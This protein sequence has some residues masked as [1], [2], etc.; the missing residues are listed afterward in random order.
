[1]IAR[2]ARPRPS[3]RS[4]RKGIARDWALPAAVLII[5]LEIGGLAYVLT[6]SSSPRPDILLNGGFGTGTLQA[7][8]SVPPYLPIIETSLVPRGST[9]AARFQ[10]PTNEPSVSGPCL[11]G[12]KD[13]S[14]LNVSTIYQTVNNATITAGTRFSMAVYPAFQS[15]SAFQVTLE[16]GLTQAEA[17][18]AGYSDVLVYYVVTANA[19]QCTNDTGYLVRT[20][21]SGT[22]GA[23]HCISAPQA[24]WTYV[25]RSVAADL[26]SGITASELDDSIITMSVSFSGASPTDQMC[27]GSLD[28]G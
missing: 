4:A 25:D 3:T 28:L 20:G 24:A 6:D 7:W 11:E 1:L 2:Y 17:S 8:Q 21:I 27:A 10:T 5:A 19:Q 22:I 23:A 26:P 15:P 18:R 13:C 12:G 14:L 9:H 16:F